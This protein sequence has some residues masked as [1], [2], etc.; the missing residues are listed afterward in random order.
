M[1]GSL[2]VNCAGDIFLNIIRAAVV[3]STSPIVAVNLNDNRLEPARR[4]GVRHTIN[5]STGDAE[6]MILDALAGQQ[7]DM[8]IDNTGVP[9]IIEMGRPAQP[10]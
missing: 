4:L 3:L 9:A 7:L 8:F 6:A 10:A 5:S 2:V 1:A